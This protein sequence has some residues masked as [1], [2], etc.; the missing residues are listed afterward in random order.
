MKLDTDVL[1]MVFFSAFQIIGG[2]TVGAGILILRQR[3]L[4]AFGSIVSGTVMGLLGFV[5]QLA[6]YFAAQRNA[7]FLLMF[8]LIGPAAFVI[9]ILA[10]VLVWD[11]LVENL[12]ARVISNLGGGAL[13]FLIGVVV[14]PFLLRDAEWCYG[15][16]GSGVL[17]IV[18]GG[19]ALAGFR[20]LRRG[21]KDDE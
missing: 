2:A 11:S 12:G 18:G 17:M 5:I 16:L 8:L 19:M 20:A 9:T 14:L 15:L 7:P 3:P 1:V 21:Q 10:R 4:M 6:G 13:L